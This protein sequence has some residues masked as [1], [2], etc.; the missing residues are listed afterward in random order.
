[1]ESIKTHTKTHGSTQKWH[2]PS[3]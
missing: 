1:M 3:P 2:S